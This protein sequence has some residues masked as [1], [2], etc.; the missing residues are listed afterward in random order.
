MW[1]LYSFNE[2]IRVSC[3]WTWASDTRGAD[4]ANFLLIQ[5]TDIGVTDQ[6]TTPIEFYLFVH[7]NRLF[8]LQ[9]GSYC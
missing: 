3:T 2:L 5:V 6:V 7:Q 4:A 1:I 8:K 9:F